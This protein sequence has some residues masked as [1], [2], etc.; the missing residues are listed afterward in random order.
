MTNRGVF[1]SIGGAAASLIV[2]GF[3]K[4]TAVP[5]AGQAGTAP[6]ATKAAPAAI[7]TAWGDPDL[8]GIWN[9]TYNVPLQRANRNADKEVLS[10]AERKAQDEAR[11]KVVGRDKRAQVGTEKD[12]AGAYNAVF[13]SVRPAGERTSLIVD[14][15]DGR[16]PPIT[17]A[18]QKEAVIERDYRNA[19]L[20]NTLTCKNKDRGNACANWEYGPPSPEWDKVP[21]F[22]NTGR[23]NRH[24][25]PEDGALGDRCMLGGNPDFAGF[26]RIVQSPGGI[27]M[28]YDIGQGQGYQRNVVMNGTPHLPASI[29]QWWGDSRGHWEGNTLVVDVTNF[30]PKSNFMGS[31]ENLHVIERWTRVDKDNL[32]YVATIE[33]PTVWTKPWTVKVDLA[34][35]SDQSNRFYTEP[36]CFEGNYGLPGLLLGERLVEAAYA[37]GRGP[38]PAS[39]DNAT[40]DGG[41]GLD[42][43]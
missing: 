9:Q 31:H 37:E 30:S 27:S 7:K 35:Q 39:L 32:E 14:P 20:Q 11:T 34:K 12:V 13:N 10:E 4:V 23:L 16:L 6:A 24:A 1:G 22:Y 33:D 19:L 17:A 41:E 38:H 43:N 28:Y 26:K 15:K 36:R 25:G 2:V 3:L 29:R 8:Q 18:A 21:P 5:V 42:L 40:C